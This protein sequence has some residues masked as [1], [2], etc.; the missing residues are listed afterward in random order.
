MRKVDLKEIKEILKVF[1]GEFK[2]HLDRYKY[3]SRYNNENRLNNK[4][5]HR[6]IALEN[7]RNDIVASIDADVVLDK[8][9][10]E[11]IFNSSIVSVGTPIRKL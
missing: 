8:F 9:W 2:Y 4:E 3:F 10:L 7:S 11:T 5:E 6:N 1:E